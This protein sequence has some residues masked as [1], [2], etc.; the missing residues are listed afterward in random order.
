LWITRYKKIFYSV[1]NLFAKPAQFAEDSKPIGFDR[2]CPCG[3]R[4]AKPDVVGGAF[5]PKQ[6][7]F[8]EGDWNVFHVHT[9]RAHQ[10]S[11]AFL[12][13]AMLE[14]IEEWLIRI[15]CVNQCF[16]LTRQHQRLTSCSATGINYHLEEMLR[17]R[18]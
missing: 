15:H 2:L 16:E 17:E 3:Q 11:Q 18:P 9:M 10:L 13:G 7:N 1:R 12:F 6:I 8:R 14:A 4:V 5:C